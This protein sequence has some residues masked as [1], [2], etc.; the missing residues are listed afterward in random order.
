MLGIASS[1]SMTMGC[2]YAVLCS[3]LRFFEVLAGTYWLATAHMI[4]PSYKIEWASD[5]EAKRFGRKVF[6]F[7][8]VLM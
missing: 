8:L 1:S 3:H 5:Y 4:F 2:R 6:V 7:S